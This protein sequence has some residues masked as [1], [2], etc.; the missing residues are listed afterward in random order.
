[1]AFIFGVLATFFAFILQVFVWIFHPDLFALTTPFTNSILFSLIFL[2]FSEELARTL[3]T[4]QYLI[5]YSKGYS[6][7]PALAFGIGFSLLEIV[8]TF[9]NGFSWSVLGASGFHLV[10]T[11][12]A[13]WWLQQ[14]RDKTSF[15][16]LL[17]LLTALHACFNIVVLKGFGA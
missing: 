10:A 1:M 3:F 6:L 7:L 5:M 16:F 15:Y 17:I 8:L 11:F 14:S 2:A 13:F 9:W 12:F 4:R